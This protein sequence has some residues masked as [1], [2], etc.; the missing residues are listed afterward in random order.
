MKNKAFLAISLF[1]L[2][3]LTI[4]AFYLNST[5]QA[6][7]KSNL[8]NNYIEERG[9]L[10]Y[11]ASLKKQSMKNISSSYTSGNIEIPVSCESFYPLYKMRYPVVK[12]KISVDWSY[13]TSNSSKTLLNI[14][15]VK[16]ELIEVVE[17][18]SEYDYNERILNKDIY[19][20]EIIKNINKLNNTVVQ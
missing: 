19:T 20:Y 9:G 18:E 5:P 11:L 8:H 10:I 15:N 1:A 17:N 7:L 6:S 3:P 14:N 2:Q 16:S 12:Y 13:N 4:Y